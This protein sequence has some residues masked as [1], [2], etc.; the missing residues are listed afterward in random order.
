MK[1]DGM[2]SDLT[3]EELRLLFAVLGHGADAGRYD[4]GMAFEIGQVQADVH[5]ALAEVTHAEFAAR[6]ARAE[7]RAGDPELQDEAEP[8]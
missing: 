6:R 1:D 3:S 2:F 7:A 4:Y 5:R 8:W